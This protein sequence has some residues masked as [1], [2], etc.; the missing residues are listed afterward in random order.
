[1]DLEKQRRNVLS[2]F[3]EQSDYL[4]ERVSMGIEQYRKGRFD[5][6]IKDCE[7]H[8]VP[9]AT[10]TVKQ[11]SHEFRL[12]S[13]LFSMSEMETKARTDE[14][15]RLF[16]ECFNLATL[17]FY[18]RDNEPEKGKKRYAK[19]SPKRYR[20]PSIEE[21]LEFCEQYGIEPKAHCLDY[22]VHIPAWV[23]RN[24]ESIRRALS[25]RFEELSKLF[26]SR[27]PSWEVTNETMYKPDYDPSVHNTPHFLA[28]DTIEWDFRTAD[29]FFPNNKLIINESGD[30]IW[31]VF[32]GNR[33]AYYMAIERA[34]QN[35]CRIDSIGMQF[36]CTM[37]EAD[38][39]VV[40]KQ[41]YNPE[42]I[43]KV[44]DRYADFGLPFQITE[45][46]VPT[47][48]YTEED[49]D[50]QAEILKNLYSIWFSHPCM[51]GI[52]NWDFVDTYEWSPHLCGLVKKDL[53]PK[54]SYLVIRDLFRKTWHTEADVFTN[55]GGC[56]C[57]HVFFGDYEV[58]VRAGEKTETIK[59]RL[60]KNS[61]RRVTLTV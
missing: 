49:E 32:N 18:W 61:D 29:R 12:G 37:K 1:M 36:H 10:V 16:S 11:L 53:T 40:G 30:N 43:Y 2:Y 54:K 47:Y 26:S 50:I 27:I 60:Y 21:C 35:G 45:L 59:V 20:R 39:A 52:I 58:T 51:E 48:R 23:D 15:K 24:L 42:M 56:A 41:M 8:A 14:Y 6:R 34:L 13:N 17:P 31:R 57:A 9:G 46:S 7:G 3:E 55:D 4:N 22:D 28:N 38:E 19:D 44:M 5:F 25:D 33:S